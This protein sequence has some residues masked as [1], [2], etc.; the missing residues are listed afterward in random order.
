M[1]SEATEL[2]CKTDEEDREYKAKLAV[3][4]DEKARERRMKATDKSF[5]RVSKELSAL[6]LD[7]GEEYQGPERSAREVGL[8]AMMLQ[9]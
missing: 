4:L 6:G 1:K 2:S 7:L 3:W 5:D 8:P 9:Y